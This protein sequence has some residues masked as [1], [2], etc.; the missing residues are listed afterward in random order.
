MGALV[1]AGK[2]ASHIPKTGARKL[3]LPVSAGLLCL[4]LAIGNPTL[5][6][7][8]ISLKPHLHEADVARAA[9]RDI[10]GYSAVVASN[11]TLW[12]A[13][14]GAYWYAPPPVWPIR[15]PSDAVHFLDSGEADH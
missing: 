4:Y 2:L 5:A 6:D 11:G 15:R 14:G 9:A 13:S 7:S 10:L 3:F 12:Y 8:R 1:V